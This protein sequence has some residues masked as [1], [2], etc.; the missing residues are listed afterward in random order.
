MGGERLSRRRQPQ[1]LAR[2]GEQPGIEFRLQRLQLVADA[3]LRQVHFLGRAGDVATARYR[4]K[5]SEHS[6]VHA[7]VRLPFD[8]GM[9]AEEAGEGQRGNGRGAA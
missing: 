6:R 8:G 2:A 1:A 9:F 4:Q 3:R 5:G 7:Y